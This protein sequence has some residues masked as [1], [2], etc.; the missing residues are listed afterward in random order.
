MSTLI[1]NKLFLASLALSIV[2]FL[3][4][5]ISSGDPI[6]CRIATLDMKEATESALPTKSK[7][8]LSAVLS[9]AKKNNFSYNLVVM[10]LIPDNL[11]LY[12][13]KQYP[14]PAPV[15]TNILLDDNWLVTKA[16][17]ES[18][19]IPY[20]DKTHK[21]FID[22]HQ[23]VAQFEIEFNDL[24]KNLFIEKSNLFLYYQVCSAKFCS[25]PIKQK[26]KL[27]FAAEKN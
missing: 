23:K 25:L 21:Q 5:S 20:W 11:Y 14:P 19:T 10:A 18:K 15:A 8:E 7:L 1:N 26:I 16:L 9:K 27:S 4:A 24:S 17:S 3:P 6:S 12:S 22:V 2:F 13:I